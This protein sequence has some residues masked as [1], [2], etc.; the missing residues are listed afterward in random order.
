MR[1]ILLERF[2]LSDAVTIGRLTLPRP[3]NPLILWACEDPWNNN[4]ENESCI[5]VGEYIVTARMYY[6]GDGPGGRPDYPTA[7]VMNVPDREHIKFHIGNEPIHTEGC[8][9]VGLD[10]SRN[11]V[12]NSKIGFGKFK[13]WFYELNEGKD[14]LLKVTE[15]R[16]Q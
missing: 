7:E 8:P 11:G 4:K 13:D 2:V 15:G 12:T 16:I 9:L 5:P 14:C 6:G 3:V 10:W 1:T